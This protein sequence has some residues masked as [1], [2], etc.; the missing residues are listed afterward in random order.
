MDCEICHFRQTKSICLP[1]KKRFI[2]KTESFVVQPEQKYDAR[3]FEL[4][5]NATNQFIDFCKHNNFIFRHATKKEDTELHYD[6][7]V[8][9]KLGYSRVEVKSMKAFRRGEKTNPDLLII[10]LQNVLGND[11]WLYGKADVV[12]FQKSNG[13]HIIR[14]DSLESYADSLTKKGSLEKSDSLEKKDSLHDS[15]CKYRMPFLY[16]RKDRKDL[17]LYTTFTDYYSWLRESTGSSK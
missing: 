3:S 6:F 1:C 14:R 7:V 15:K 13:F 10:E 5:Q 11:G 2:D 8:R 12:F 9:N 4:G 17:L 16:S